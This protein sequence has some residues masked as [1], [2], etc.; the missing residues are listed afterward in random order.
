MYD[1]QGRLVAYHGFSIDITVEVLATTAQR[2]QDE[3]RE[4]AR[5]RITA[6]LNHEDALQIHLQPI[7]DLTTRRAVGAEALARFAGQPYRPPNEWFDEAWQAG[8][9]PDLEL[10]AVTA[11]GVETA[12][13]VGVL[14]DTGVR[15]AQG[16]HL[17]RPAPAWP[18]EHYRN[19]LLVAGR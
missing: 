13:E 15:L 18:A 10:R 12:E 14:L 19:E 6:V 7:V 5:A 3:Q 16:Y 17:G 11:E 8:L 9:G 2:D 4:A 1:E